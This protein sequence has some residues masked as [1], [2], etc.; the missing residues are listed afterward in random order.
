MSGAHVAIQ[1]QEEAK[2]KQQQEEEEMTPY[3]TN[4]LEEDWEFK[5]VRS[6]TNAFK[7]YDTIERVKAEESIAGWILVEKF[8]DGRLR[9][10]RPPNAKEN[11]YNLPQGIDPYR[12]TYGI[13]EGGLALIIIGVIAASIGLVFLFVW[14]FGGI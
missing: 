4:Q 1:A 14:L 5:I 11:D 10:K 8:D 3:T 9:F 2:K 13:G 7:K 6:Q 12:T